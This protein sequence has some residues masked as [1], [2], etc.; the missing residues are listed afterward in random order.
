MV[1]GL[2]LLIFWRRKLV[3]ISI[4]V[5]FFLFFFNGL[6][7]R[8]IDRQFLKSFLLFFT[9]ISSVRIYLSAYKLIPI[10]I[11]SFNFFKIEKNLIFF[12][13]FVIFLSEGMEF[14][15][16]LKFFKY[17]WFYLVLDGYFI[18]EWT[19][20]S[21]FEIGLQIAHLDGNVVKNHLISQNL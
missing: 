20:D 4:C 5:F 21:F 1:V 15:H 18:L 7:W 11:K 13:N 17:I 8:W 16:K 12:L 2:T 9:N 14:Y 6:D 19:R 10:F 3:F